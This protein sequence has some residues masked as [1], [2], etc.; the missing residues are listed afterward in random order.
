MD[1]EILDKMTIRG[2]RDE[3][4]VQFDHDTLLSRLERKRS[5]MDGDL[6]ALIDHEKWKGSGNSWDDDAINLFRD[7]YRLPSPAVYVDNTGRKVNF[8]DFEGKKE[9]DFL[10]GI[11]MKST[12]I[13]FCTV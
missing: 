13:G 11:N 8:T 5:F 4:G 12:L 2:F 6:D 9:Y 10:F 1:P 3:W 7:F